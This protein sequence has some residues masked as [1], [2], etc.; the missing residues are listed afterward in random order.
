[1]V[2]DRL[3]ANCS[4]RRSDRAASLGEQIETLEQG[5]RASPETIIV[6]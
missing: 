1:M 6:A 3:D 5:V 4:H 2:V